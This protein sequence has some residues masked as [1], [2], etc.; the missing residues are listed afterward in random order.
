MTPETIAVEIP[1][2]LC[3]EVKDYYDPT[4]SFD[5]V[6]TEVLEGYLEIRTRI[7]QALARGYCSKE[8]EQKVLD[9]TLIKSMA[10]EL[11]KSL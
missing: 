3:E 10:H 8:N 4:R 2:E 11:M 5:S 7:S 1:D 6:I 9:P